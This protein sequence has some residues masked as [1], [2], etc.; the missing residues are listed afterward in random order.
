[1]RGT[2]VGQH[3]GP[4][5]ITGAPGLRFLLSAAACAM[6]VLVPGTAAGAA[7]TTVKLPTELDALAFAPNA[8]TILF[9]QLGVETKLPGRVD[10]REEVVVDLATDGSPARVQV[11][12]RLALTGTGDFSFKV[13]GPARDVRTLPESTEQPGLRKGALLWQGFSGGSKLLAATVDL[14]PDQEAKRLP[15]RISLQMTVGGRPVGP[16]TV[17]DGPFRLRLGIENISA[18]PIAVADAD[19]DPSVV[20]PVLDSLRRSLASERRPVPGTN[21]LPVAVRVSGATR[22]RQEMI[23]VPFRVE[24]E[25][26]FPSGSLDGIA[27]TGGTQ[28]TDPEGIRVR[29]GAQ[30]GGGA[31]SRFDLAVDGKASRLGLPK[32]EMT[33]GPALPSARPLRPPAGRSWASAVEIAPSRVDGREM[34]ARAMETL[35]QVARLRQFDAYLGNP[36]VQGTST[37][38]YRFQL[39]P[40]TRATAAPAPPPRAHPLVVAFGVAILLLL[41]LG[42]ALVWAH[43]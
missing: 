41:L 35:W 7:P 29:F 3:H 25:L 4:A 36:D 5:R 26:R 13:P 23:E 18:V 19:A 38:S 16:G 30:L 34:L 8:E 28:I 17:A 33:G 10:D 2:N 20:G 14:F 1:M 39:A 22:Q 11:T 42:L 32:L 15:I 21:G 24:G 40:P 12:Q 31:A 9:G 37:T 6:A 27:V 43:S